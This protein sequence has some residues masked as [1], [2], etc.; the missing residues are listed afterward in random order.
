[1]WTAAQ[2]DREVAKAAKDLAQGLILVTAIA[3]D[4]P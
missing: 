1:L 3:Q 4:D 2:P